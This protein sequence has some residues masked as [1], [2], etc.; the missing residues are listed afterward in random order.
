M[1]VHSDRALT[2]H[3]VPGF[4]HG[5]DSGLAADA[6][7]APGSAASAE[8][9]LGRRIPAVVYQISM[10]GA[11]SPSRLIESYGCRFRPLGGGA[12]P[13][14]A[15][16]S[17]VRCRCYEE[18]IRCRAKNRWRWTALPHLGTRSA[19]ESEEDPTDHAAWIVMMSLPISVGDMSTILKNN[20][21]T[22]R[23]C[24]IYLF[25]T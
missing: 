5:G 6:R 1:R 12:K 13:R 22:Y 15:D 19:V 16:C 24:Y 11:K 23:C 10:L 8:K 18:P 25:K 21:L 14:I 9:Q 4:F 3:G 2:F 7:R 17:R 20:I